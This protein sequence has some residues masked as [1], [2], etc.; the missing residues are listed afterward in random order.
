MALLLDIFVTSRKWLDEEMFTEL[1][2]IANALPGPGFAQMAFTM[3]IIRGGLFPGVMG[4]LIF[5]LP[6]GIVMGSIGFGVG[7]LGA[8]NGTF[9][10]IAIHIERS[11]AAVSIA[12][13]VVAAKQLTSKILVDA[14]N[15]TLA[16][17]TVVLVISFSSVKWLIPMLILCGGLVTFLEREIPVWIAKYERGQRLDVDETV[18]DT[19]SNNLDDVF[20]LDDGSHSVKEE[21]IAASPIYFSYTVATG[22]IFITIYFVLLILSAVFRSADMDQSLKIF[23]LFYYVGG[24]LFGGAPVVILLYDYVVAGTNWLTNTEFLMGLAIINIMP[25]PNFNMAAY[26]GALAFRQTGWTSFAGAVLAWVGIYLPGLMLQAGV[27]PLWRNYRDLP[28]LKR[29]FKGLNSVAVGLLIAAI[30]LLWIKAIVLNGNQVASLG[31]YPGWTGVMVLSFL[32][33]ET[34]RIQPWWVVV[35]GAIVGVLSWVI[36]GRK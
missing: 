18:N 20:S 3:P 7:R 29:I 12:L 10:Q 28:V 27:L 16:A 17:F 19:I 32:A 8:S 25:G 31:D 9:P 35:A 2:A 1:F 30:Y 6:G 21:K 23:C 11:L 14:T 36:D 34:W 22:A 24:A 4:F 26:C 33:M 5:A 15:C 13:V